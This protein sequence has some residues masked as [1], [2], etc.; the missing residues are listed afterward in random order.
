MVS[1]SAPRHILHFIL[2][3]PKEGAFEPWSVQS[4][5]PCNSGKCSLLPNASQNGH[6][7]EYQNWLTATYIFLKSIDT[8]HDKEVDTYRRGLTTQVLEELDRLESLKEWEWERQATAISFPVRKY[9]HQSLK[10]WLARMLCREDI[11]EWLQ[12]R[13]WNDGSVR[14]PMRDIFDG[15]ALQSLLGPEAGTAFLDAPPHELRL[16][17]SL[18]ADGF[19]PYQMKEAKHTVT[20]TAIY[21]ICLNLPEHLRYLPE[22][23]YLVGVVP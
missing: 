12:R 13:R 1:F 2:S 20:S 18:S 15:I 22:N 23:L 8:E 16:I 11:E 17:F 7:L 3:P 6:F 4:G 14:V 5:N 10:H 19:N 9:L 21:M